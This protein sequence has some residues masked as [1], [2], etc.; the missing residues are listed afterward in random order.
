[1]KLSLASILL[2]PLPAVAHPVTCTVQTANGP[3]VGHSAVNRSRVVEYLGIPYAQP[4]IGS[5]RFAAPQK[6]T[7]YKTFVAAEFVGLPG[8]CTILALKKANTTGYL[9]CVSADR[10]VAVKSVMDEPAA[11]LSVRFR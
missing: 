11:L 1:M 2:F 3:V 10:H 8:Y 9:V 5:L 4:P 6:Y 7:A